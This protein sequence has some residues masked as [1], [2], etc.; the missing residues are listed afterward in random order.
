MTSL[1]D[2]LATLRT[3]GLAVPAGPRIVAVGWATVERERSAHEL[4]PLV[5][6]PA[7]DD[8]ALGAFAWRAPL[9]SSVAVVLLEPSTE[10]PL[11][12]AL[13]RHGEGPVAL[14]VEGPPPGP[15]ART[16]GPFALGGQATLVRPA[17]P[18]GPF[19]LYHQ[20]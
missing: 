4:A 10:G 3:R 19:L 5:F 15:A 20:A 9:T 13:A 12:A 7:P 8:A 6:D 18:W 11:A 1:A 17:R 16:A 14:W 2:M